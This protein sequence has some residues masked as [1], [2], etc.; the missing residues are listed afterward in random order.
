MLAPFVAVNKEAVAGA[1]VNDTG[2]DMLPPLYTV[3]A[4]VAE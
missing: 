3:T 2:I 1:T 4:T